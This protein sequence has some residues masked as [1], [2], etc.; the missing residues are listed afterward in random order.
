MSEAIWQATLLNRLRYKH[1]L[2]ISLLDEHR[3]LH[4][5]A[6]ALNMSQPAATR[7]LREIETTFECQLFERLPRGVRPT[8]LGEIL[9]EFAH[10]ALSRLGRCAE[11]LHRHQL[12]DQ[13][14]LVL[15]AI[16][17]AAPDLVAEA[18]VE[19]KRQR[20][21]LQVRLVGETSDQLVELLAQ[22][23]IDIAIARYVTALQHNLFDF[24]PLGNEQMMVVVRKGHPLDGQSVMSL[25]RLLE[26]WPW[27]LQPVESPARQALEKEFEL[28]GLMSPRDIIE[29]GSIFAALQLVMRSNGLLVMAETVL[30]DYLEMERVVALPLTLGTTL[31]SYGILSRRN[32]SL[33]EPVRHLCGILREIA[34]SDDL[35][36]RG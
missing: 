9:V 3:N 15:G 2:L 1:L 4:Q 30:R 33:S 29:C 36:V 25:E 12:G 8:Q 17:G 24:E 22:S 28:A 6:Q 16:M 13:G 21:L 14:Q 7:M 20:P 11:S 23:R 35:I 32:E 26:D 27:I 19:M 18:V 34:A 10:S 5:V 31:S